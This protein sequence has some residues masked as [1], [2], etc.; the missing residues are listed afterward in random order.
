[1]NELKNIGEFGTVALKGEIMTVGMGKRGEER[2]ES[3]Y[4]VESIRHRKNEPEISLDSV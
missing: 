4:R 1:M 2:Y 3:C